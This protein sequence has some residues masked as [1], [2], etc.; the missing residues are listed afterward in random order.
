MVAHWP[1]TVLRS[2]DASTCTTVSQRL[3]AVLS[4]G[5]PPLLFFLLL[6]L[7]GTAS[8]LRVHTLAALLRVRPGS[9]QGLSS[10]SKALRTD[11]RVK[12]PE[13]RP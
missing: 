11:L 7:E 10:G 8:A 3:S 5:E 9:V 2:V 6:W 13:D 12:G 4:P 1:C